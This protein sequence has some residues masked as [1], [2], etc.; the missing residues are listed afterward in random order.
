MVLEIHVYGA[1]YQ[2]THKGFF[3]SYYTNLVC[4]PIVGSKRAPLGADRNH[5]NSIKINILIAGNYYTYFILLFKRNES[6]SVFH[7]H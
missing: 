3:Y 2:N 5:I 6:I 1:L 4:I 7:Y